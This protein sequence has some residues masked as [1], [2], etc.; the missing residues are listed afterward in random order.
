MVGLNWKNAF[1]DGNKLGVGFGS[2][3]SYATSM[4]GDS[5]PDDENFAFEA[6]YDYQVSDNVTVTPAVFWVQDA[7]G[8]ASVDGSDTLG[9][10][11]KT[12]FKF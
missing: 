6:Y 7:D 2:Y 3:S 5:S 10:L 12:T 9:A 4:K 1:V 8:N 11:V